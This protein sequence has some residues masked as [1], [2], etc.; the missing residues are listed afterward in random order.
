MSKVKNRFKKQ[1]V[2]DGYDIEGNVPQHYYS[3]DAVKEMVEYIRRFNEWLDSPA[4]HTAL[5]AEAF[6]E[7]Q[8]EMLG[9]FSQVIATPERGYVEESYMLASDARTVVRELIKLRAEKAAPV[10]D[11][12]FEKKTVF[13]RL[14]LG[15]LSSKIVTLAAKELAEH[16]QE[17]HAEIDRRDAE[18]AQLKAAREW[19]PVTVEALEDAPDGTFEFTCKK[20]GAMVA[21][22]K[23]P[24]G[25][26]WVAGFAGEYGKGTISGPYS[27]FRLITRAE[28][29]TP[30]ERKIKLD[31][32]YTRAELEKILKEKE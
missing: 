31:G 17:C 14:V 24:G 20:N 21:G 1:T 32:E 25:T 9:I 5:F 3:A 28:D 23:I 18:L 16:V 26:W 11:S 19:Q 30:P 7:L 4:N 22:Q 27:H 8:N 29:F 10:V 6:T 15:E 2:F 12:G 13:D